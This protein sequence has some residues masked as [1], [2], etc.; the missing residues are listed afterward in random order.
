MD[1]KNGK[2]P[3]DIRSDTLDFD[4][5]GHKV[6]YHGHVQASQGSGS[7]SSD[8]LEVLYGNDFKDLK[9]AIATGNVHITQGGRWATGERADLDQV[10][11][12]VVLTGSPVIHD[13]PD[14]VTG[15]RILIYLD[16]DKSVVEKAHA[17]IFPRQSDDH[18]NQEAGEQKTNEQKTAAQKTAEQKPTD[19]TH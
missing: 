9:K 12:T 14:Q 6:V 2:Q 8:N 16:T 4:Y 15:T 11:R 17:V 3:I 5:K 18:D 13:G 10:A 7:L 19:Q 1:L